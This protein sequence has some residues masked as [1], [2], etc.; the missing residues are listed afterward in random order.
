MASG[1]EEPR[2][3]QMLVAALDVIAERGFAET[4][5]S[6]VAERAGVSPALVIYYFKTKDH[7]L[8]EAMRW[9]EDE[10]YGEVGRRTA[11]LPTAVGRLEEL[12]AM[13]CLPGASEAA[14]D[15]WAIWLDLWAQALRDPVVRTVR[16]QFDEHFRQTIRD[17]VRLGVDQGEFKGADVDEDDFSIALSAL[18]DGF[19]IQ[20]AL[21]DPLVDEHR[22]FELTMRVA[23]RELGFAWEGRR[24]VDGRIP[25]RARGR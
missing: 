5:I 24:R 11:A 13:T 17:I 18:L 19:A 21:D 8:A 4:R 20:I 7:L 2:R 10:W 1:N 15:S 16:E 25:A 22:A 23:A 14:K 6:D 3:T 9:S 12:V